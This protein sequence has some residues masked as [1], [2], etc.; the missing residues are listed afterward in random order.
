MNVKE[1]VASLISIKLCELLI[2]NYNWHVSFADMVVQCGNVVDN[3]INISHRL[4][5]RVP[6]LIRNS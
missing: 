6:T 1:N 2:G 3:V 5:T 4:G